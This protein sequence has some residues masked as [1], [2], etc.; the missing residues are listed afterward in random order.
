[1]SEHTPHRCAWY[2]WSAWTGA[3]GKQT[4]TG[5]TVQGQGSR[6]AGCSQKFTKTQEEKLKWEVMWFLALEIFKPHLRKSLCNLIRFWSQSCFEQGVGLVPCKISS[7]WNYS[8]RKQLKFWWFFFSWDTIWTFPPT[9][10]PVR[11]N[12]CFYKRLKCHCL[13]FFNKRKQ[14]LFPALLGFPYP[15]QHVL[16]VKLGA[17]QSAQEKLMT[18]SQN[19]HF[20]CFLPRSFS[21]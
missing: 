11:I 2:V 19:K 13:V 18:V 21:L 16:L 4:Q 14:L 12:T 9:E 17:V 8:I 15:L 7:E 20:S 6:F 3:A 1:M 10:G 5:H